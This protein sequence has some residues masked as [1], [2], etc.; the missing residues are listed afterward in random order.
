VWFNAMGHREEVW[1]SDRFQ[2]M[3]VGGIGWAGGRTRADVRP[4]LDQVAPAAN[5]LP[6]P[7]PPAP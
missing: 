1:D 5:T 3:L 7:R 4:N 2:A 6:P